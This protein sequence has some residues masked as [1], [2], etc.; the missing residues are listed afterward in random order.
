MAQEIERKFLVDMAK[1][2]LPKQG[3]TICQGYIQT[4]DKT[5]V[6]IR[7]MGDKA[8]LT[9][10]GETHGFSRSEFEYEIPVSDARQMLDELCQGPMVDKTRYLIQHQQHLWELDIFAGDNQGLIIAEVELNSETEQPELPDWISEEVTGDKRYY[11]S[12]LLSHPFKDW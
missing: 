1:V 2:D 3:L 8:F 7:I 5:T 12:N 6:R 9:L 10:K 11:N 4:A